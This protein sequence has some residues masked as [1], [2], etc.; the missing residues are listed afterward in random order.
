MN[1]SKKLLFAAL[2]SL[3]I[4]QVN[5]QSTIRPVKP[6]KPGLAGAITGCTCKNASIR[7]ARINS[8]PG[9]GMYNYRILVEVNTD[10]LPCKDFAITQLFVSGKAIDFSAANY[11]GTELAPDGSFRMFQYDV[12]MA[13]LPATTAVGAIIKGRVSFNIAGTC[14]YPLNFQYYG[15]IE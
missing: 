4:S 7:F 5:A 15:P 6:I 1:N 14:T 9:N 12:K 10:K 11:I 3:C 8:I 2:A 13:S